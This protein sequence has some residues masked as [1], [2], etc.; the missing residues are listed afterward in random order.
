MRGQLEVCVGGSSGEQRLNVVIGGAFFGEGALFGDK[1]NHATVRALAFSELEMLLLSDIRLIMKDD[2]GLVK[3]IKAEA[4]TNFMM[5]AANRPRNLNGV[6]E[7]KDKLTAAERKKVLLKKKYGVSE[8]SQGAVP[9]SLLAEM[10][11][12]T[13]QVDTGRVTPPRHSP[14]PPMAIVPEG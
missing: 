10:A 5:H 7:K 9:I 14:L 3:S 8:K 12:I 1:I 6:S 13:D 4:R 2:A 11:E